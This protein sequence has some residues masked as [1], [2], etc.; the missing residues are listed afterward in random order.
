MV[1]YLLQRGMAAGLCGRPPIR[2]SPRQACLCAWHARAAHL[3]EVVTH[4]VCVA[5]L[6]WYLT[7]RGNTPS[8]LASWYRIDR[9]LQ[10]Y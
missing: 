7:W 3:C 6:T 8:Q 10:I 5:Y 1:L 4:C 9:Y 2:S